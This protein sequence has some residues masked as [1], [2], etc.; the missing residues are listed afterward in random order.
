MRDYLIYNK[1]AIAVFT[2]F[3]IISKTAVAESGAYIS[4]PEPSFEL[5]A[6]SSNPWALPPRRSADGPQQGQPVAPYQQQLESNNYGFITDDEL[7]RLEQQ[8]TQTQLMHGDRRGYPQPGAAQSFSAPGF[9]LPGV[10]HDFGQS[11][12]QGFGGASTGLGYTNPLYHTPAV[13][14]WGSEP[15]LLYEGQSFP[16]VPNEAIGGIPPMHVSPYLDDGGIEQT[17]DVEKQEDGNVF[18]PFE[19]GRNGRLR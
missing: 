2:L 10:V 1:I 12:G 11:F 8:Q 4:S 16:W 9:P 13:S 17:E 7:R 19:F 18:N 14:P 15:G 6:D 3:A 5:V